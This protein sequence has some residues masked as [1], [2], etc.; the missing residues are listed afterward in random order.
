M[1]K[2]KNL[3]TPFNSPIMNRKEGGAYKYLYVRGKGIT[4][5]T[6]NLWVHFQPSGK[7]KE[8]SGSWAPGSAGRWDS[9][10]SHI[11]ACGLGAPNRH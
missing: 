10:S 11:T 9:R 3:F 1:T 4:G 2:T 5:D 8:T 7:G 6:E